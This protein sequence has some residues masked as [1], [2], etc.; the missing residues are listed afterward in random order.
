MHKILCTDKKN[1]SEGKFLTL[2]VN[3]VIEIYYYLCVKCQLN[4]NILPITKYILHSRWTKYSIF[5]TPTT[6]IIKCT[7]EH[8]H[9]QVIGRVVVD[10]I[11]MK[12]WQAKQN[13]TLLQKNFQ[14]MHSWVYKYKP[15]CGHKFP[16]FKH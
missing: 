15:F 14:N 2:L 10:S 11:E 5:L 16:N 1:K 4:F 6:Y 8:T 9:S 13:H 7:Q 3:L 12:E